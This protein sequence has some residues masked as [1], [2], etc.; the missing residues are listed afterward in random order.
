V[1]A[2]VIVVG[3]DFRDVATALDLNV[4][5]VIL[6]SRNQRLV[7]IASG[8]AGAA[9]SVMLSRNQPALHDEIC[10]NERDRYYNDPL[11]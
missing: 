6:E 9:A 3:E 4:A 11:H 1:S 10:S 8:S 7:R 2:A 5:T